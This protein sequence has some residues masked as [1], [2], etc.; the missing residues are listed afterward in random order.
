MNAPANIVLD[1]PPVRFARHACPAGAVRLPPLEDHRI[2]VHASRR[3]WSFCDI[4]GDR[5]LRS[6]GDIDLVPAGFAGGFIAETACEA[7]EIR[8]AP[9]LLRRVALEAG[10]GEARL[11]LRHI[12]R[13]APIVHLASA[14]SEAGPDFDGNALYAEAIGVAIASQLLGQAQ[15]EAPRTAGLS[16]RQMKRLVDH[17]EDHLD[18]PLTIQ[19]L[20]RE[21]GASNSHLRYWFKEATGQTLHRYVVTRRVLRARLLLLEGGM[22]LPEVALAAG[23]A[24]PSHMARWMRRQLGVSPSMVRRGELS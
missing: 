24:H 23:F 14:L 20:A 15:P 6:A 17:I 1:R 4:T 11:D 8:L 13:N 18:R 9:R 2:I 22:S 19:A 16:R 3:T 10:R 5:H 7:L 12:W 21:I